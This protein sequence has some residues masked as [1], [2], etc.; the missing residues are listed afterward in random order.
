MPINITN[1]L[2]KNHSRSINW[3]D[4]YAYQV[5]SKYTKSTRIRKVQ[6]KFLYT[7]YQKKFLTQ[8]EVRDNPNCSFRNKEQTGETTSSLLVLS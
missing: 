2:N 7:E 8:I 4:G 3:W 5:P 6:Y 1:V